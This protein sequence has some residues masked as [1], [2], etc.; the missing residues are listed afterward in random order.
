M[1]IMTHIFR[2]CQNIADIFFHR[3]KNPNHVLSVCI[4][5][6]TV[7]CLKFT[8]CFKRYSISKCYLQIELVKPLAL[9]NITLYAHTCVHRLCAQGGTACYVKYYKLK[10]HF[11][12]CYDRYSSG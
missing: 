1:H 2:V 8:S 4:C 9:Q 12:L 5:D 3:K 6:I 7:F 11:L 10:E